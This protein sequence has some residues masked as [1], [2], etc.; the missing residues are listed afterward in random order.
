LHILCYNWKDIQ[1]PNA[2]GAEVFTHQVL[3][4]LAKKGYEVTLFT[5]KF[6]GCKK[7]EEVD[8]LEIIR[9]GGKYTVY[10]KAKEHYL[11][12]KNRYDLIIDEINTRPFLTPKFVKEKPIIALIHQLAREFWFYETQFPINY[13]GY[14]FLEKMWLS[15][16]KDIL[17][18]TVSE[19][20]KKDL[21]AL[22]FRKVLIVPEG[23]DVKPLSHVG[24]KEPTPTIVFIGRLKRAKLPDHAL[25]AFH[26]IKK[27]IND[28]RLW[29]IGDGYMR[30]ELE[31]MKISDVTFYGHV[32]NE[33]KYSLLKRAHI[34]LV[35]GVREGWGLVVTESNSMGTPAVAYNVPGLRD[36]VIDGQ[37]GI[38][39]K[40]N[41]PSGLAQ[42][43]IKILTNTELLQKLSSASLDYSRRFSWDLTAKELEKII[44]NCV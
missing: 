21:E 43:A 31:R 6:E 35:P 17:T 23:L 2:G 10:P 4:R 29:V 22:G 39:T 1:N 14:Y 7:R 5:S 27:E 20:T 32:E 19:S 13:L 34:I 25:K 8:G 44:E 24:V 37:T 36:S 40:E 11:Q 3:K 33:M 9:E 15:N 16:Y 12:F 38:L 41:S 18:I 26:L 42:S 30:R 28:V